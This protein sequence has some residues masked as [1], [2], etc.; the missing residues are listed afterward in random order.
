MYIGSDS[1]ELANETELKGAF[2][3]RLSNPVDICMHGR[4]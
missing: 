4:E 3:C 2:D 1:R